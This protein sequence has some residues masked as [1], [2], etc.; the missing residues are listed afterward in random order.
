MHD[1]KWVA[2]DN[3]GTYTGYFCCSSLDCPHGPLG[4][5]AWETEVPQEVVDRA[6]QKFQ[7][8]SM[9]VRQQ[10]QDGQEVGQA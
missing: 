9:D 2:V 6:L 8:A 5:W 4:E 1:H 10:A 3:F 7:A